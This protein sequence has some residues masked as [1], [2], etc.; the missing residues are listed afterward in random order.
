MTQRE[1]SKS[2]KTSKVVIIIQLA[3][4][5]DATYTKDLEEEFTMLFQ[6]VE[7]KSIRLDIAIC[8]KGIEVT[9]GMVC[10]TGRKNITTFTPSAICIECIACKH[11]DKENSQAATI[12]IG[13]NVNAFTERPC[14]HQHIG[15]VV[16]SCS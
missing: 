13:L 8:P 2:A 5:M 3:Q 6:V 11:H 7:T 15:L 10:Y 1:K 14:V 9:N 4:Q 16:H 12:R